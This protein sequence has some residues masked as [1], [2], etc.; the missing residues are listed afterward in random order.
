MRKHVLELDRADQV[1]HG[2]AHDPQ[3]MGL[4]EAHLAQLVLAD[5]LDVA[6]SR[7]Q[8]QP[9]GAVDVANAQ[10]PFAVEHV[11]VTVRHRHHCFVQAH[12]FAPRCLLL[13]SSG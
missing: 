5:V 11:G 2:A 13:P 9:A 7:V 3:R 6:A 10:R 4:L 12:G 8:S 1:D